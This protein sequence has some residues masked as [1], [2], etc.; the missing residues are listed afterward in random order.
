MNIINA[1]YTTSR[2]ARDDIP[3]KYL[4]SYG[5]MDCHASSQI[6][7]ILITIPIDLNWQ[8]THLQLHKTERNS[9]LEL[10]Q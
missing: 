1:S 5:C 3:H 10:K 9:R 8:P 7:P 6:P 2:H 4:Q